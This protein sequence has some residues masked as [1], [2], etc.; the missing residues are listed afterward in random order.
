MA[1]ILVQ[2]AISWLLLWFIEK[3]DL[4]VL[5]FRPNVERIQHFFIFLLIT[6]ICCASGFLLRNLFGG[7][8]WYLNPDF[9]FRLLLKG[10]SWHIKSVLYEELIFRGAILYILIKRL[11]PLRAILVSAIAFGIYHWFS[12]EILGNWTQMTI[13]LVTTGIMGIL[14]AYGYSRTFSLSIPIAIHLGWNFIQ[15]F[16]FPGGPIGDGILKQVK[17]VPIVQVS[18]GVYLFVIYFPLVSMLVI[19]WILIRILT[20]GKVL[21]PGKAIKNES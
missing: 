11:G 6:A 17:P 20:A 1:G 14:L 21:Y 4:G 15:G 8:S 3:K 7:E 10:L 9:S 13:V 5:G 12:F 18:F 2:L 19:N 16:V